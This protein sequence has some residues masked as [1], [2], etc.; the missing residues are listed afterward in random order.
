ME[1]GRKEKG[2]KV[3]GGKSEVREDKYR[4]K[5][6]MGGIR[7]WILREDWEGM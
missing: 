1:K 6:I 3:N 2:R 5:E 4:Q 7:G